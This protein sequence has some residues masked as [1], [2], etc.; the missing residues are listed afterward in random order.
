MSRP[1]HSSSASDEITRQ[2]PH[3][4]KSWIKDLMS[5]IVILCLLGHTLNLHI[6]IESQRKEDGGS[7]RISSGDATIKLESP[8]RSCNEDEM[9]ARSIPLPTPVTETPSNTT[10]FVFFHSRKSG[11]SAFRP[12][13]AQAAL[14]HGL[15]FFVPCQEGVGG[16]GKNIINMIVGKD[17]GRSCNTYNLDFVPGIQMS[18][19]AKFQ[20][21]NE[22]SVFAGHFHYDSV[23]YLTSTS[24]QKKMRHHPSSGYSYND[25]QSFS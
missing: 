21:A 17:H 13:I 2:L 25:P 22:L 10:P 9:E 12:A 14:R 8:V 11:G 6:I 5:I 18:K 15:T 16:G 19:D 23:S 24:N 7:T 20:H 4:T 1:L 3:E